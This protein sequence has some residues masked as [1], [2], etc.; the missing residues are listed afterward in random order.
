[1]NIKHNKTVDI[2]QTN[3]SAIRNENISPKRVLHDII[4]LLCLFLRQFFV[5]AVRIN[6]D[7]RKYN[8]LSCCC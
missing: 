3:A 5:I 1:M 2:K 4:Y 8:D 6:S 7:Y